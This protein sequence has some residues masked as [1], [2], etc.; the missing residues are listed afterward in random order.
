M[1]DEISR[2]AAQLKL[3]NL[4][5]P[6]YIEYAVADGESFDVEA[7]FG[8]VVRA[9]RDRSRPARVTVRAGGYDLDNTGFMSMRSMM[10][11]EGRFPREL[12]TEDDYNAIRRDLWLA[13]DA[14][15]KAALEQLAQKRA[16]IKT[17]V[18]GEQV[19]D[20][21]REE[22]AKTL[23]PRGLIKYDETK[24]KE[25]AR[26]LSAI[27]REFPAVYESS[28]SLNVRT[29][30]K[31]FVNSE[32]TVVREPATLAMLNARASTQAADGMKLKN[33]V[34]FCAPGLDALPR[35]P[36]LRR[37]FAEWRKS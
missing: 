1:Q 32:G 6:Y 13:T 21:S 10:S 37:R 26:R 27:L 31:Y 19:P 17:K 30:N 14:S 15:Y 25:M 4:D 29:T 12:V 24:L 9:S 34:S 11:F 35:M 8:A 18:Q 20:L 22:P 5:K 16:F 2:S 7:G 28:V 36:S 3:E 33:F 23:S